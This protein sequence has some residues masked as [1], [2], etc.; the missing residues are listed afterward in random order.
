MNNVNVNLRPQ[1]Q[2]LKNGY[3]GEFDILLQNTTLLPQKGIIFN[4][5]LRNKRAGEGY[6]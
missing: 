1:N 5:D 3:N 2:T 4:T 6:F